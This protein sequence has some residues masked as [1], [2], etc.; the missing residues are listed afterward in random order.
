MVAVAETGRIPIDNPTTHLELTMIHEGM[1]LEYSGRYLALMEWAAQLKLLLYA[2][3]VCNL[4][5]P[6]GIAMDHS[7]RAIAI[8]MTAV[9]FKLSLGGILLSLFETLLAKMRL[10]RAPYFLSIAFA[11]ALLSLLV[12]I[13]LEG[14]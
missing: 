3:L 10:F 1:I 11:L 14:A 7:L 9:V 13:I 2:V 12:K 8:G 5:F 6:I 4:F